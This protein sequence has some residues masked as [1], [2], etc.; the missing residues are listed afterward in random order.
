MHSRRLFL[1]T[2]VATL[3]AVAAQ[4]RSLAAPA[5]PDVAGPIRAVVYDARIEASR[6]FAAEAER[7]GAAALSYRGDIG[8]LW[9]G[10]LRERLRSAPA[11][12]AGLTL[13]PA[14]IEMRSFARDVAYQE[15]VRRHTDSGLVSWV[16]APLYE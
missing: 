13:E 4:Q 15:L 5:S 16:F 2:S 3:A 14:A 12:V 9:F 1:Q 7:Y 10:E 8:Q 11:I 6:A